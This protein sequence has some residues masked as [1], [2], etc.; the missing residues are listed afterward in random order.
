MWRTYGRYLG[1]PVV[2]LDTLKG[3]IPALARDALRLAAAPRGI[4]AGA[5]AMLGH[6]R[7]LFLRF[8]K[9]GKMVATCGGVFFGVA[10]WVALTAGIVWL[11]VFLLRYASVASIVAGIALPVFAAVYGYPFRWCSSVRPRRRPSSTC[12]AQISAR[13]RAGTEHRFQLAAAG[14]CVELSLV[15]ARRRGAAL[16]ARARRLRDRLVRHRGDPTDR[17]DVVTGPAD[18]CD[19]G[20][21][22]RR[23]RHVRD[24]RGRIADDLASM[25]PGGGQDPTRIPRFDQATFLPATGST[26]RRCR[27]PEPRSTFA[28]GPATPS[29][30]IAND[31]A[32]AGFGSTYKEYIVYY[33][34]PRS[35]PDCAA[36]AEAS[37][38]G[39]RRSR[40]S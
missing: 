8:A 20:G 16:W 13:L 25:T 29:A 14:E 1:A 23:R 2:V 6:W 11:A 26:S 9:G 7:P 34:G 32:S 27:L 39:P 15:L 35:E 19:L 30:A 17:P 31:L 38:T 3:F 22:L 10:I 40:S 28:G 37:S 36:S 24:G 18:P 4:C 5:A 21:P 33:D 12:T